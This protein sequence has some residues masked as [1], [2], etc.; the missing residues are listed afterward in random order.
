MIV[1]VKL[2]DSD[3]YAGADPKTQSPY[4]WKWT[5]D[6]PR[7]KEDLLFSIQRAS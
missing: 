1:L 5:K 2:R 3:L 4:H 7:S 6:N